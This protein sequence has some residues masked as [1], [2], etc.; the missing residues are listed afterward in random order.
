MGKEND[1]FGFEKYFCS[2][3]P[4]WFLHAIKTYNMGPPALISPEGMH[5]TDFY[6]P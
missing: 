3:F 1:E 5:A 2:Y 6:N 4:K